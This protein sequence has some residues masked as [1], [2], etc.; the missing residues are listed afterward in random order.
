MKVLVTSMPGPGHI[1]PVVPVAR[2]LKL[3]G[4]DVRWAIA[5]ESVDRVERYGFAALPLASAPAAAPAAASSDVLAIPPRER[6]ALFFGKKFGAVARST[7]GQFAAI[8]DELRP[9]LII[10]DL[11]ALAAPA[12]AA[13]RGIPKVT[14]AFSG[15]FSERLL[16]GVLEAVEDIWRDEGVDV[17]PDAGVYD[18]L[19]LHRFPPLLG[20]RPEVP[21]VRDVRPVVFDGGVDTPP[22]WVSAL[23]RDRP[24]VYV[25]LGTVVAS[26]VQWTAL[27]GALD[28]V[29]VDVVATT[30]MQVDP[31]ELGPVPGNVRLERYVPQ[32]FVLDRVG[33]VISHA[34][35]GTMLAAADRGL[36]QV[37]IPMGADMWEN[38]DAVSGAGA[39]IVLE[40]TGRDADSIRM[41]LSCVLDNPSFR[42]GAVAVA[43]E[44]ASMPDPES[45]IPELE[46]LTTA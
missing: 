27:F 25:T 41:T 29:D 33:A 15:R 45:L 43:T 42:V 7:R 9:D 14:V 26:V 13:A 44:I 22:D 24:A 40:E 32:S 38:A 35:A 18:G 39:G 11:A 6:R 34:G 20:A 21:T 46:K 23:G 1:H 3:A 31:G 36:P 10:H 37:C 2:A 19:Y 8:A 4:H 30:G 17:P 12:V 5:S 16:Q 28:G